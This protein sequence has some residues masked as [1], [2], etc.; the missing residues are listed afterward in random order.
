MGMFDRINFKCEC[1]NEIEAQSKSGPCLLDSYDHTA[2]PDDVAQDANRHA[3]FTCDKCGSR[4]QFSEESIAPM[5]NL[6]VEK[7][8]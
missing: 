1:G 6:R 5:K 3:P 8:N 2:V 4:Y 7:I